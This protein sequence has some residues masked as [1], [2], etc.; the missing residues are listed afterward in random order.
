MS[1]GPPS[2]SAIPFVISGTAVTPPVPV[3][4]AMP[5]PSRRIHPSSVNADAPSGAAGPNVTYALVPPNR[6]A[7]LVAFGA[8]VMLTV[9]LP[10]STPSDAVSCST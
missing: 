8:T 7:R 4:V 3:S 9:S 2:A 10:V 1:T 5:V 6:T